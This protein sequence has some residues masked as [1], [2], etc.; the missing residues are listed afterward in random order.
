MTYGAFLAIFLGV[1]LAVL[2]FLS[3]RY[4]DRRLLVLILL[5]S[6]VAIIYTGPWDSAIIANG[7]WSYGSGR[8]LGI[9]VARV[10]LEEIVF[11]VLQVALT[12]IATARLL[13][14]RD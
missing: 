2:A 1:P 14:G 12:A 4:I 13:G 11:Y 7:V 5:L 3:R 6:L 10:P 9:L 8:V